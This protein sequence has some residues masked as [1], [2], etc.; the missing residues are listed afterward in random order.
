MDDMTRTSSTMTSMG[1]GAADAMRGNFEA[2]VQSGQIWAAGWQSI[3]REMTAAAQARFEHVK[4]TYSAMSGVKSPK[5]M[6]ELQLKLARTAFE[7]A[8]SDTT[9]LNEASTKLIEQ[10]LAPITA[11]MTRTVENFTR[12]AA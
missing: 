11:R 3:G 10:T 7:A 9:K 4:S 8:V 5:E 12:P 2:C 6:I 1:H